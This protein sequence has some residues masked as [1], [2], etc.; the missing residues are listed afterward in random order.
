[1]ILGMRSCS[2]VSGSCWKDLFPSALYMFSKREL[3]LVLTGR[4]DVDESST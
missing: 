4:M 2:A 1:M 3:V